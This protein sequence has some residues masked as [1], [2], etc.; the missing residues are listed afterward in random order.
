MQAER[1]AVFHWAENDLLKCS[2][3]E[4]WEDSVEI[5]GGNTAERQRLGN[6][7]WEKKCW[8]R[9]LPVHPSWT[10][11]CLLHSHSSFFSSQLFSLNLLF[12]SPISWCVSLSLLSCR[13][14]SRSVCLNT[15]H[16][17]KRAIL[18]TWIWPEGKIS[19]PLHHDLDHSMPLPS[20]FPLSL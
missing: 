6:C 20:F 10:F 8:H 2:H 7:P 13:Q 14:S 17:V 1:R 15:M 16:C 18:T 12:Y 11:Y 4:K 19:P 3:Y 5:G 9:R